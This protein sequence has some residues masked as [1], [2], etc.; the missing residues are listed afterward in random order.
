VYSESGWD[1]FFTG[2]LPALIALALVGYVVVTKVLDG[3]DLPEAPWPLIILGAGGLAAFLVVLRLL[4]GADKYGTDLD[5][6][7]GLFIAAIAAV[8][9]G[10]GSFLKFQEE[11]GELPTKKNGTGTPG[12]GDGGAPTPF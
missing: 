2:G 10:V 8:A 11:G 3:I 12:A 5:R 4:I 9:L 7:Y 6:S 1:R